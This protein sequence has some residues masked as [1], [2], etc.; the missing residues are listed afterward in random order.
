MEFMINTPEYQPKDDHIRVA[1]AMPEVAIGDV[2]TNVNNILNLYLEALEQ[3]VSLVTFPELSLTGYSVQD[4]VRTPQLLDDAKQGLRYLA[5]ETKHRNTAA[6]VGLPLAV[7]NGLY[8][9]AALVAD[10]E[11]KGIVP[12]QNLPTYNEF[13]EKRWFQSWKNQPNTTVAIGDQQVPFGVNQ[14]FRI[15]GHTVGVEICED[16]WVANPPNIELAMNGAT[17]IANPSA[18]PESVAKASYRSQLIGSTAARLNVG[19]IYA[20]ADVTESTAEIVMG[21][22]SMINES[23]RILAEQ[24]PLDSRPSRLTVADVDMQH[25]LSDRLKDT[26]YPVKTAITPTATSIVAVQ[27]NYRAA[28]DPFPFIPKGNEYEVAE[29]CETILNIQAAGLA[30][31]LKSMPAPR[32]VM[33]LSGGLDSTLALLVVRRAA[34]RLGLSVGEILHTLTMP[35]HA[36]SSR[37]QDNA[38]LLAASLG[39]PNEEIPIAALADSQ[40]QAIKHSGEQDVTYENTQ[41]RIRQAFVFNKGNQLNAL[42]L[43]TGDL[44]EI[45][46]GWATYGGDQLSGY[47]PNASIPKTLVR[48]LVAH[49]AARIGGEP[50]QILRDILDTPVS[51]E[52]VGNGNDITQQTEDLIGPYELHDFFLYRY[53]RWLEPE[54]K[55][56]FMAVKAF[57]TKY[58][59][60]EIYHW[61][62]TFMKRFHQNQWKRQ[63][64]PDG[65]KVGLSL[66]PRGDWRMPPEATRAG[67]DVRTMAEIIKTSVG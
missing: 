64:M 36:S 48:S 34:D 7:Q 30:R 66:G 1:T 61:L 26:N 47:N 29:R 22:H 54:R 44:S 60:T 13:Y 55:I 59:P 39:I 27:Q 8:N 35:G 41:A 33:G 4:L 40:L 46:L 14:L 24:R 63:A 45:A 37:T 67:H 17:L 50:E 9:C 43:G 28:V 21:G 10:G 65:A 42:A 57:E 15:A 19:Y 11:V 58:K 31:K 18:S 16:L 6:I 53:L 5:L 3:D 56:G 12:K 52:L 62:N 20:S 2:E 51:P 32:V 38:A 25:I 23:G 49:D